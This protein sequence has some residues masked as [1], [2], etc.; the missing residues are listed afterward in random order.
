MKSGGK[1]KGGEK[2]K[3]NH[4]DITG[5]MNSNGKKDKDED[6]MMGDFG[7]VS[8]SD[9]KKGEDS[10]TESL[11]DL[12]AELGDTK[13]NQNE[14]KESDDDEEEHHSKIKVEKS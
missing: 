5:M 14:D 11:E 9:N 6:D 4:P 3:K 2:Y 12:D 7:D 8:I 10:D 13:E 1:A